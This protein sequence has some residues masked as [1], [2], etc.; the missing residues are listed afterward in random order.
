[1]SENPESLT[2]H[3]PYIN[4]AFI[5]IMDHPDNADVARAVT[6]ALAVND[7]ERPSEAAPAATTPAAGGGVSVMERRGAASPTADPD[8]IM[9][10]DKDGDVFKVS[11]VQGRVVNAYGTDAALILRVT[12][13]GFLMPIEHVPGLIEWL[14]SRVRKAAEGQ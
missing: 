12:K 2:R 13:G 9:G 10:T 3:D 8:I 14:K 7:P 5:S 6:V 11:Y 1:M 4:R